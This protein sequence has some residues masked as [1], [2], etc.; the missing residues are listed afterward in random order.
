MV[1]QNA[2]LDLWDLQVSLS[3]SCINRTFDRWK[4]CEEFPIWSSLLSY[5]YL[6][7]AS[8]WPDSCSTYRLCKW[9]TISTALVVWS[10]SL[11]IK[12]STPFSQQ[13]GIPFLKSQQIRSLLLMVSLTHQTLSIFILRVSPFETSS[14]TSAKLYEYASHGNF[15]GKSII[16]QHAPEVEHGNIWIQ[17]QLR[18]RRRNVYLDFDR[19]SPVSIF[20]LLIARNCNI[21]CYCCFM[22]VWWALQIY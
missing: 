3:I 9:I 8:I 21:L 7:F 17:C 2:N 14:G 11:G 18:C 4:L 19:V 22:L 20:R 15:Q 10:N 5:I 6:Y 1:C 16:F 12:S 13:T